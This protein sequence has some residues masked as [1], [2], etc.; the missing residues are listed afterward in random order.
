MRLSVDRPIVDFSG[1]KC[2]FVQR[3]PTK[4]HYLSSMPQDTLIFLDRRSIDG[5]G[6]GLQRELKLKLN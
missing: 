3:N 2:I 5:G 4:T 1:L 6:G